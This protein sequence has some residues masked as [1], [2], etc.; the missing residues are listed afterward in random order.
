M[1]LPGYDIAGLTKRA[2]AAK[3]GFLNGIQGHGS[4]DPVT[5]AK[6]EQALSLSGP[7]VR[8]LV[9][10]LRVS[11]EPIGS[12]GKGYWWCET[13]DELDSTKE[14]LKARVLRLQRVI[15]GVDV[16]QSRLRCGQTLQNRLDI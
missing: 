2:L 15:S 6:I 9:S 16:A 3:Q 12:G 5:S 4:D 11:G 14:H 1:S 7:E 8:A 10:Y 13:A